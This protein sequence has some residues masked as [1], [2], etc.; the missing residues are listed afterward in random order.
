MIIKINNLSKKI[1]SHNKEKEILQNITF[2]LPKNKILTIVGETGSGKSTLAKIIGG[3]SIPTSGSIN[4]NYQFFTY[5][6]S[7]K[8]IKYKNLKIVREFSKI[9][10][11]DSNLQFFKKNICDEIKFGFKN[12][13]YKDEKLDQKVIE[14]FNFLEF[15]E[16]YKKTNP[17]NLSGGEQKKLLIAIIAFFPSKLLILDEPTA[18]MDNYNRIEVL[19]FIKKILKK[20]KTIIIITHDLRNLS[21]SDYLLFLCKGKQISFNKCSSLLKNQQKLNNILLQ[22]NLI[23]E[24]DLKKDILREIN[25][26]PWK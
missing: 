18:N 8:K 23:Q 3:F 9:T 12:L 6:K 15:P 7:K 14:V 26:L 10:F 5:S 17:N 20:N 11:Q 1:N 25:K 24:K 13:G 4:Y 19:N 22:S 2:S 21:Y 16:K